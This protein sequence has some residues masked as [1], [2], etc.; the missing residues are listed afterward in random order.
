[1]AGKSCR[2]GVGAIDL[3]GLKS[4]RLS[5]TNVWEAKKIKNNKNRIFRKERVKFTFIINHV[6]Y[7]YFQEITKSIF[8]TRQLIKT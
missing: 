5:T 1:V 2:V 4:I 7:V 8:A 6:I 3:V